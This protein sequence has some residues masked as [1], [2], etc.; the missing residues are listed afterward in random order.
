MFI[1]PWDAYPKVSSFKQFSIQI[2]EAF[3][4][5][6]ASVKCGGRDVLVFVHR[7]HGHWQAS[8][9]A[10]LTL[11]ALSI[12]VAEPRWQK[13]DE[14]SHR[15]SRSRCEYPPSGDSVISSAA[16]LQYITFW[17]SKKRTYSQITG[18]SKAASSLLLP[19][20][21]SKQRRRSLLPPSGKLGEL[22]RGQSNQ[23]A[24]L[25]ARISLL[26]RGGGHKLI[27]KVQELWSAHLKVQELCT[28][29]CAGVNCNSS[30]IPG[31]QPRWVEGIPSKA[32]P[33]PITES[34]FLTSCQWYA[35]IWLVRCHDTALEQL[36]ATATT[37]TRAAQ[38]SFFV[39]LLAPESC[40]NARKSFGE[41][42]AAWKVQRAKRGQI[43]SIGQRVTRAK[44]PLNWEGKHLTSQVPHWWS[45]WGGRWGDSGQEGG[46]EGGGGRGG[47]KKGQQQ[48]FT[49][50]LLH[51]A[52]IQY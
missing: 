27:T 1:N 38:A 37:T 34:S 14:N 8:L 35:S 48:L 36:G 33:S 11:T 32:S 18:A 41:G 50:S 39:C 51:R 43:S 17:R 19:D 31:T 2:D 15:Q 23:W 26:T 30:L 47:D 5:Q 12:L 22:Q 29:R 6:S 42:R 44:C 10:V 9:A 45:K 28:L 21:E 3:L 46:P 25:S 52:I 13:I 16:C 4:S 49:P 7:K 20:P 24:Q 40:R